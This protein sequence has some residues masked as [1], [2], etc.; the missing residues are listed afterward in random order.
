METKLIDIGDRYVAVRALQEQYFP[1]VKHVETEQEAIRR[2]K[3]EQ[4]I[5]RIVGV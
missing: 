4:I 5:S 3:L 2:I 1:I